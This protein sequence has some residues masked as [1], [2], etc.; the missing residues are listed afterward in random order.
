MKIE[1]ITKKLHQVA[2]AMT[3]RLLIQDLALEA[4]TVCKEVIGADAC[5]MFLIDE[6]NR[7][8]LFMVAS[9][10]YPHDLS[11]K[12]EYIIGKTINEKKLGVTG[13]IAKTGNPVQVAKRQEFK[14]CPGYFGGKY[15]MKLW[16]KQNKAI[17]ESFYGA[18]LKTSDRIFGV[19]KVE[20]KTP[21]FF[22]EKNRFVLEIIAAMITSQLKNLMIIRLFHSLSEV[23]GKSP[24]ETYK[25]YSHFAKTCAELV[26]AESSSLFILNEKGRLVLRGDY[27]HDH[28]FV[29]KEEEKYTYPPDKGVTGQVFTSG[30]PSSVESQNEVQTHPK[31]VNKLY[32]KQWKNGENH[33][34]HSWYQFCIGR[35]PSA[36]GVMKVENKIG[37]DGKP[38]QKGGFSQSEK[39]I[40]EILANSVIPIIIAGK[41]KA[42]KDLA[43]SV[44]DNMG[45]TIDIDKIFSPDLLE[46]IGSLKSVR[47]KK[48]HNKILNFIKEVKNLRGKKDVSYVGITKEHIYKIGDALG[49]KSD[50]LRYCESLKNFEPILFQLPKY[51]SHFIH[52][53]N[54]FLNGYLILN[55]EDFGKLRFEKAQEII[56]NKFA[57]CAK[58]SVDIFKIWFITAIFHDTGYPIGKVGKWT[59]N[60]LNT[61]FN[62]EFKDIASRV[63]ETIAV[64]L[65]RETF[66]KSLISLISH[67]FT[68]LVLTRSQQSIISE[69]VHNFFFDNLSESLIASLILI[70]AAE[71]GNIDIH[72]LSTSVSAIVLDDEKIQDL[73][74]NNDIERPIYY[75]EH[76]IAFLL[77]YCDTIQEYGRSTILHDKKVNIS[78]VVKQEIEIK[79]NSI[80]CHLTYNKKPKEWKE[81]VIPILQRLHK[82]WIVP[83]DLHFKIF[84]YANHEMRLNG[85]PFHKLI[86]KPGSTVSP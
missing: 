72:T 5:S 14:Q 73:L 76:P 50:F 58:E 42:K 38:I 68:C 7:N 34:C 15:D 59:E 25:L 33:I 86:F 70:R 57:D 3:G 24:A 53:L 26:N 2:K 77:V 37:I 30:N 36:L 32:P 82:C 1:E 19:L 63:V 71:E 64:R 49:I 67:L 60:F 83:H 13:W 39:Q 4:V 45:K 43:L 28:S 74:I 21:N 29:D 75:K 10:G 17:C 22:K 62:R 85:K 81:K 12:A 65:F 80:L 54:V 47:N 40:L 11:N 51:R 27:G 8:R 55:H 18:P 56:A 6:K 16:G 35:P 41:E 44:L 46:Q 78:K 84:Y 31:R 20:S 61:I 48:L 23:I 66:R 79:N 9:V 52:Q 69:K